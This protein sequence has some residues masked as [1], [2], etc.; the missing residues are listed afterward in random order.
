M[1][2]YEKKKSHW[3]IIVV[4]ILL[5]GVLVV[6]LCDFAPKQESVEVVVNHTAD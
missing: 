5:A 1:P 2:L 3:K 6:A 4:G